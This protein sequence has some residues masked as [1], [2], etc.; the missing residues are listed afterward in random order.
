[1]GYTSNGTSPTALSAIQ[2]PICT[3]E[4]ATR[5]R[6]GVS[7]SP[8]FAKSTRPSTRPKFGRNCVVC[9]RR[10]ARGTS[11]SATVNSG[12]VRTTGAVV[13]R[14]NWKRRLAE[15]D[16]VV[17]TTSVC[18]CATQGPSAATKSPMPQSRS[19]L[20]VIAV[21]SYDPDL[22]LDLEQLFPPNINLAQHAEHAMRDGFLETQQHFT[23]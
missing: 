23:L 12:P 7:E 6:C 15:P 21:G 14:L 9:S 5:P 10:L 22:S 13:L 4:N 8:A 1:M 18:A 16:S 3:S 20:R 19:L 2:D 11:G 17:P